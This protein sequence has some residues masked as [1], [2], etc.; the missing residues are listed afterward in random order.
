MLT[1]WHTSFRCS[2]LVGI[3]I[4]DV[5]IDSE[6]ATIFSNYGKTNQT[7]RQEYVHI[8]R[9]PGHPLCGV[10]ALERYMGLIGAKSGPLFRAVLNG[11]FTESMDA[12]TVTRIVKRFADV[13]GIHHSQLASNS[14][15]AGIVTQMIIGGANE[16]EVALHT[17]RRSIDIMRLYYRPRADMVNV[18]ASL[19]LQNAV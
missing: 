15:R 4:S 6:K 10:A 19:G 9:T 3:D 14:M 17:R 11:A 1:V 16:I 18:A 8:K 2:A 13:V 7:G 5:K 12:K